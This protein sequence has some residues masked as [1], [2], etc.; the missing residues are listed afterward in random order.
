MLKGKFK[1]RYKSLVLNFDM[2][3]LVKLSMDPFFVWS[4]PG[5]ISSD[6]FE[7]KTFTKEILQLKILQGGY[8]VS[9]W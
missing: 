2:V 1:K 4:D 9:D 8:R 5:L 3:Y 6:N 7:R